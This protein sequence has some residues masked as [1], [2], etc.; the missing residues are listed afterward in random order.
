MSPAVPGYMVAAFM[1]KLARL[2]V[3]ACPSP[4]I[5]AVLVMVNNLV[6]RH[7]GMAMMV[8]GRK[9]KAPS[10]KTRQQQA[11][12]GDEIVDCFDDATTDPNRTKALQ[13]TLWELESLTRHQSPPVSRLATAVLRKCHARAGS[14]KRVDDDLEIDV[15]DF[16]KAS[17]DTAFEEEVSA[18]RKKRKRKKA[19]AVLIPAVAHYADGNAPSRLWASIDGE[20]W[21]GFALPVIV[22]P[23]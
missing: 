2:A 21:S 22:E 12:D 10:S 17:Y 1:K 18:T 4:V 9:K 11:D 13:S 6:L 23:E 19:D 7:P 16:V 14:T 5:L 3:T 15:R 8:I 20:D